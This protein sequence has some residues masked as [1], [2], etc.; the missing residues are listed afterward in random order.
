VLTVKRG[1]KTFGN[2][3]GDYRVLPGDR[4][5]MVGL[6][7]RFAEIAELFRTPAKS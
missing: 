3:A 1:D 2:P 4:M 6:A 5:I 7:D